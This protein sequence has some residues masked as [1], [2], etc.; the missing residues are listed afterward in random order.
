MPLKVRAILIFWRKGGAVL[1]FKGYIYAPLWQSVAN[2]AV[3]VIKSDNRQMR[4]KLYHECVCV[5]VCPWRLC[6]SLMEMTQTDRTCFSRN[7]EI[8]L[9]FFSF[10]HAVLTDG[11]GENVCYH[12]EYVYKQHKS[13]WIIYSYSKWVINTKT[14]PFLRL[15]L[16][17]FSLIEKSKVILNFLDKLD[18]R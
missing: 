12:T 8:P 7:K 3:N 2:N 9:L 18:T 15:R 14:T 4:H 11:N 17:V 5:F 6:V 1:Y 16:S 13:V 10:L